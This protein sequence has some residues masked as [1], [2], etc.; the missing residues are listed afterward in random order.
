M[1]I[2]PAKIPYLQGGR[3]RCLPGCAL[4]FQGVSL[5]E[6]AIEN[7]GGLSHCACIVGPDIRIGSTEPTT[8]EALAGGLTPRLVATDCQGPGRFFLFTPDDLTPAK[9]QAFVSWLVNRMLLGTP[10]AYNQLLENAAGHVQ[11]SIGQ[12][13]CSE[14]WGLA[15]EHAG[16]LRLPQNQSTLAPRPGDVPVW[17]PGSMIELVGPFK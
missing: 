15:A 2:T 13:F 16:I 7:W 9:Q 4:L 14:A 5:L 17:W 11:E 12:E 1:A 10:Y 3:E 6:E 8:I